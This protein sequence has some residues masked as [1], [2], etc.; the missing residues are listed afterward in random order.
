MRHF[1]WFSPLRHSFRTRPGGPATVPGRMMPTAAGRRPLHK[2]SPECG[3]CCRARTGPDVRN[4][5]RRRVRSATDRSRESTPRSHSDRSDMRVPV[6]SSSRPERARRWAVHTG[7]VIGG[8]H[9]P[10][11]RRSSARFRRPRHTAV[12]R[13][14]PFGLTDR[15]GRC[16]SLA[17]TDASTDSQ[18]LESSERRIRRNVAVRGQ[19][20]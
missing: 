8:P 3:G 20:K 6:F 11:L 16:S 17:L 14:G 5:A 2:P 10:A 4:S 9:P 13:R 1:G 15:C 12:R 7:Q 18:A 19:G